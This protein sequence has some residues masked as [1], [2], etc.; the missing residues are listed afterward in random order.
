MLTKTVVRAQPDGACKLVE[1]PF[2]WQHGDPLPVDSIQ[3]PFAS[4]RAALSALAE[5]GRRQNGTLL[6][7]PERRRAAVPAGLDQQKPSDRQLFLDSI[8]RA[9]RWQDLP[10]PLGGQ[11]PHTR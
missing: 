10:S 8:R 3:E 5:R 6:H 1:V 7:Q 4:V 9:T 2:S 11:T